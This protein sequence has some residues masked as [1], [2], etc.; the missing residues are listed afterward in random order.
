MS[1]DAGPLGHSS[2]GG[3]PNP[4]K[5]SAQAAPPPPAGPR[6]LQA[7]EIPTLSDLYSRGDLPP[8]PNGYAVPDTIFGPNVGMHAFAP[9]QN[10]NSRV[11]VIVH[12]I[13][14]LKVDAIVNAANQHLAAGGGVCGAIFQGAG[15]LALQN[16]CYRALAQLGWGVCPVGK[17][18]TTPA[19]N[20][21]CNYIIHAVG[22]KYDDKHG[23]ADYEYLLQMCYHHA[24]RQAWTKGCRTVAFPCISTQIYKYPLRDATYAAIAAVRRFLAGK[25][26]GSMKVI[27]VLFEH[28]HIAPYFEFLPIYFPPTPEEHGAGVKAN[29]SWKDRNPPSI[30]SAQGTKGG[31]PGAGNGTGHGDG[32]GGNKGADNRSKTGDYQGDDNGGKK[33]AADKGGSNNRTG[34]NRSFDPNRDLTDYVSSTPSQQSAQ[35]GSKSTRERPSTPSTTKLPQQQP[36]QSPTPSTVE[37]RRKM[38]SPPFPSPTTNSPQKHPVQP[39]TPIA[40]EDLRKMF[41]PPFP[42]STTSVFQ[43]KSNQPASL[44]SFDPVANSSSFDPVANSSS[45]DPVANSSSDPF[46][47]S[48]SH[49][50]SQFNTRMLLDMKPNQ[51]GSKDTKSEELSDFDNVTTNASD[52]ECSSSDGE[53]EEDDYKP[54]TQQEK[55]ELQEEIQSLRPEKSP[56]AKRATN[57]ESHG[58]TSPYRGRLRK[59]EPSSSSPAPSKPQPPQQRLRLNQLLFDPLSRTSFDPFQH[60][61]TGQQQQQQQQPSAGQLPLNQ[62]SQRPLPPDP[63][64]LFKPGKF[65]PGHDPYTS[66]YT[67]S[68]PT[69]EEHRAAE[70]A[71][72]RSLDE[73]RTQR[74]ALR[75]RARQ[76]QREQPFGPLGERRAHFLPGF[77][78]TGAGPAHWVG[79]WDAYASP[80][81]GTEHD[82]DQGTGTGVHGKTHGTAG[83]GWISGDHDGEEERPED[84]AEEEGI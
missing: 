26:G 45:F 77:R 68:P 33:D 40:L 55:E 18:V 20:L 71:H 52:F 49:V 22:P 64:G 28:N 66:N 47:S 4:S 32:T 80:A 65:R 34:S 78:G 2:T 41:S 63:R 62:P 14:L 61:H 50:P 16:A 73:I 1:H 81:Q 59:S 53:E 13:T 24:L 21:P 10:L 75:R 12:D 35:T 7:E 69:P 84:M 51:Q 60:Q 31:K 37:N 57:E 43:Q 3:Q 54:I 46:V 9:S 39:F 44:S 36:G 74:E 11:S 5:P 29:P 48:P 23:H 19:F 76:P 15:R 17:A 42:S 70:Q 72:A 25:M 58:D 83:Q 67:E 27:F 8:A 6:V 56:S 38:F 30:A 82:Q 79:G